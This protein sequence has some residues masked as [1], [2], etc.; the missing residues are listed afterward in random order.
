MK[1]IRLLLIFMLVV[2]FGSRAQKITFSEYSKKEGRDIYFEILG[3][4]GSNYIIY[5]NIRQQHVLTKYDNDMH[6]VKTIPLDFVPERTFNIDFVTY[7]DYFFVIYQYQKNSIVYCKAMKI[8]FE[9][10]QLSKPMQLDTTKLTVFADNKIYSTIFSEDKKRILV[11]KRQL[12]DDVLTLATK[13]YDE[14]LQIIDSTRQLMDFNYD[15]EVYSDLALDNNGYFLFARETRKTSRRDSANNLEVILHKPGID[16]FRNYK[17]SLGKKLIETIVIKVD[18]LNR[19]YIINSF[20]YGKRHGN[21]EG[22][23]TSVIDMNGEKPIRA[24][25]NMF[26]DTLRS[27]I[28]STGQNRY[29]FDNLVI[30]NTI[31]KKSAGFV[32]AAEDSYIETFINNAWNRQY[33]GSTL[34]YSSSYDYYLANPYY[35]GY[36]PY[37]SS[38]NEVNTRYYYDDIVVLS[39][40]SS[41][42]LEWN[43]VIHKKQYDVDDDNFLSF[44]NM[45]SGAEL[46]FFFIENDRQKQVITNQSILPGGETKRYPTVRTS[47]AGYGFMPRLAKQ[48]AAKTIIIPYIYRNYIEFAKVNF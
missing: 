25:F 44:S 7:P 38:S 31:V 37:S 40:D 17:L 19:H 30:R 35:Y 18:N 34:P 22:L 43:T 33:S 27:S 32:V 4:F 13:L 20:Y 5:K 45:N 48:V 9:G 6:F 28:N 47:E 15:K 46:H 39:L 14:N 26:S 1:S 11:Y 10:N 3:K 42:K 12:K 16:T 21:V 36:R 8:G 23:F 24:A 29:V 41:L 2:Q